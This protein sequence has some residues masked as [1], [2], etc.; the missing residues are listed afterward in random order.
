MGFSTCGSRTP[1][2]KLSS[3]A[4]SLCGKRDIPGPGFKPMSP[5]LQGRFLTTGPVGKPLLTV[6]PPERV[7]IPK[8]VVS[9]KNSRERTML[10]LT[11]WVNLEGLGRQFS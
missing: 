9:L 6:F 10:V 4:E 1:E 5:A 3:C 7:W 2:R 8:L 11:L